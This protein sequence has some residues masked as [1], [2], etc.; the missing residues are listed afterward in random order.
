LCLITGEKRIELASDTDTESTFKKNDTQTE[1]TQK[2]FIK[3]DIPVQY[4][5]VHHRQEEYPPK[6]PG[7]AFLHGTDIFG[8]LVTHKDPSQQKEWRVAWGDET[9]GEV[10]EDQRQIDP[11]SGYMVVSDPYEDDDHTKHEHDPRGS[12]DLPVVHD[13]LIVTGNLFTV[14]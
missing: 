1:Y 9:D 4:E 13:P 12:S 2:D 5:P 6:E 14:F 11:C 8:F 7:E 3:C 10:E